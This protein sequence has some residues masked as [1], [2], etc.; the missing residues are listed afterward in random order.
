MDYSSNCT[1]SSSP[2][3]SDI[4]EEDDIVV[5]NNSLIVNDNTTHGTYKDL[6][7]LKISCDISTNL[8]SITPN[9]DTNENEFIESRI[10][11]SHNM[12][13]LQNVIIK[14]DEQSNKTTKLYVQNTIVEDCN[15]QNVKNKNLSKNNITLNN[16]SGFD[17]LNNNINKDFLGYS[18]Q[19][20]ICSTILQETTE[21][22]QTQASIDP[23]QYLL[24]A[25]GH[26][27]AVFKHE[28]IAEYKEAF[29]QYKLA[30]SCLINGIQFDSNSARVASVKKKISKYLTQAEHLYN[31]YLNYNFSV[32]SKPMSELQYYKVLKV[33]KSVML[34]MD[35]RTNYDRIIKVKK[36]FLTFQCNK[37]NMVINS[38]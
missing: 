9:T 33:M 22:S 1:D 23:M 34:V 6:C 13:N 11:E 27:N 2:T 8:C 4:S 30:I 31:K 38:K 18:I 21:L 14:K 37:L 15:V 26:M 3:H 35:I 24:I 36:F 5:K 10:S 19:H 28:S 16:E 29:M 17:S 25:A 20:S 12:N 32:V 7:L